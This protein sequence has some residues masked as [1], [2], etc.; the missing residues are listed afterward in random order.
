MCGIAGF[1]GPYTRPQ[2]NAMAAA[3]AHRGP[4]GEGFELR[5]GRQEP[6][7][8]GLAHRRLS[9]IDLAGGSQPMWS[10]DGRYCI[11]FN[12]EIYNY[13]ELRQELAAKGARFATHSDTEVIVE[14]WRLRGPDI[15]EALS[16]MFAFG[17]WD[18]LEKVWILARDRAG[19]KPLYYAIPRPGALVFASEIKPILPFLPVVSPDPE[20]LCNYLLY[21]WVAGPQTIFEGVRHLPPGHWALW[22]PSDTQLVHRPYWEPSAERSGL[23]FEAAADELEARFD[24]AVKAHMVADVP[25]GITLSGGLDSSAVLSAMIKMTDPAALDAFTIGFGLADDETP[26]ARIM[27][28]HAGIRHHTRTVPKER[29][30]VDFARL[31]RTLEE[32]IGHPVLQTTLEMS[33]FAREKVKIVLIGE[34]SDE[35]FLGYPQYRLLKAPFRYAPAAVVQDYFLA[36]T[37][38]MPRPRELAT[39]LDPAVF[40]RPMLDSVSHRFDPYFRSG[41]LVEG[42]QRFEIENSLVANQLARIDKLTMAHG[43]EARVPFLD[44][45]FVAFSRSLPLDHKLRQG[46]TKAILRKAM[47]KR[48]PET[49]LNRPKSGKKGTQALLPYLNGLVTDGPLSELISRET[50]TRRGW[51]DADRVLSYLEQGNSFSVRNHPIERRRRAKFAYGLAVIEQW[52]RS[53]LD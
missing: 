25:V 32:P 37:C 47:S 24:Q 5:S 29:V 21:S 38:L 19:I 16:G 36:V 13:R 14:G 18:D 53:Y 10:S 41:D 30:A 8:A 27:A 12:G 45:Q 6:D 28:E 22:R 3:L 9:I 31:V 51:M 33:A 50:I 11:I 40:G 39:M 23:G 7:V 42:A 35:L 20:A 48:L 15:L 46:S 44:N 52:A 49:I 43:L 26:F 4:D 34:G 2:L 1:Y 17:I